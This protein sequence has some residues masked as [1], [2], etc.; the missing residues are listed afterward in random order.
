MEW[1]INLAGVQKNKCGMKQLG[2]FMILY[3]QL[4]KTIKMPGTFYFFCIVKNVKLKL[5]TF[6]FKSFINI[7]IL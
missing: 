4:L 7:P 1:F 5:F 6:I 3:L 2:N